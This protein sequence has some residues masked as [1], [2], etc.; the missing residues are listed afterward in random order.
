MAPST[1]QLL[2]K[3]ERQAQVLAAA[4]TAFARA[5]Y[6]ATSMDDV[7]AE[8]GVTRL[9]V[10]R[11]FDSK[12]ELYRAVLTGV[13]ERLI[14]TF[15]EGLEHRGEERGWA[16][17]GL[18]DVAREQPDAFRL[19]WVHAARE[20]QFA[21]YAEQW[22]QGAADAADS[23][24]GAPLADPVFRRWAARVLLALLVDAVLAWL[25]EGDPARDD[26][27]LARTSAGARAMYQT[28]L[29]AEGCRK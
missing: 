29:D 24:L 10:Y 11:H 2:P 19:L 27:F 9:I 23:V 13:S 3:A 25:D 4:A 20:P 16:A 18:L 26:E 7:A 22:R 21:D 8:A 5:G 28:W 12:E 6:A 15:V 1:R 17:R 14:E